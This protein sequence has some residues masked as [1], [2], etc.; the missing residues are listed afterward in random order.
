MASVWLLSPFLS[1]SLAAL[2]EHC[3]KELMT[4]NNTA[5]TSLPVQAPVNRLR[6]QPGDNEHPNLSIPFRVQIEGRWLEGLEISLTQLS[7]VGLVNPQIGSTTNAAIRFPFSGFN[8]DID[9]SVEVLEHSPVTGLARFDFTDVFGPQRKVLQSVFNAY[10]AGELT[11]L[12]GLLGSTPVKSASEITTSGSSRHALS[13]AGR[14]A[15]GLLAL[16]AGIALIA[17]VGERMHQRMFVTTPDAVSSVG[18]D[19]ITLAAPVSGLLMELKGAASFGQPV[20]GVYS[21]EGKLQILA[22]PCDCQVVKSFMAK[23][24]VVEKGQ[25]IMAVM[26][27]GGE[28]FINTEANINVLSGLKQGASASLLFADGSVASAKLRSVLPVRANSTSLQIT[29]TSDT[30]LAA[31]QLGEPVK[32]TFDTWPSF[33]AS[34]RSSSQVLVA[35]LTGKGL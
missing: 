18:G 29:L 17:F 24:A 27:K 11:Q 2:S 35:S 13:T 14:L 3:A 22:M 26:P 16:A 21:S 34:F 7:A 5:N 20:A 10:I 23:G 19:I 32:V 8:V 25:P 9:A 33:L 4:M 12:P 6:L 15:K 31:A 30:P 28:F 1:P